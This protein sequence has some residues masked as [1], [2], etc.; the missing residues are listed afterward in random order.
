MANTKTRATFAQ[1]DGLS[2]RDAA[3]MPHCTDLVRWQEAGLVE[4]D[5]DIGV[6]RL[7]A[8][9]KAAAAGA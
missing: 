8:A 2:F 5:A 7:T 3:R 6:F 4:I 1:I 9:G